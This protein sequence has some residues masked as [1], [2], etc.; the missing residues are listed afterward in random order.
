MSDEV[1]YSSFKF[2]DP[3]GQVK[4]LEYASRATQLG[5]TCVALCNAEHGVLLAHVP[6]RTRLAEPQ[7]KVFPIDRNTLFAF[8]GITN[9]GMEV[10]EYLKRKVLAENVIKDRQ[11]HHLDVFNEL[12]S[13]CAYMGN[14]RSRRLYGVAGILMIDTDRVHLVEWDS[15]G[16]AR[17]TLGVAIGHR[18]QSCQTIL[19]NHCSDIPNASVE[20]LIQIGVRSLSNAHPDP[21]EETLKAEDV[22]IYIME[23]G[24]GHKM[25]N[26]GDFMC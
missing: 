11:I 23:T 18:C 22:Y 21:E 25:V 1:H 24:K 5:N 4:Q 14:D 15:V 10:N 8:A 2:F 19:D 12:I 9:D 6:R 26:G 3:Q 16:V 13:Q 20:D 17:E 7:Q